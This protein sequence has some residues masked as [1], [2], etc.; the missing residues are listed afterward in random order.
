MDAHWK[1]VAGRKK[2]LEDRLKAITPVTEPASGDIYLNLVVNEQL[3]QEAAKDETVVVVGQAGKVGP[4]L[5]VKQVRMSVRGIASW[6]DRITQLVDRSKL[7]VLL[8]R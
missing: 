5:K 6:R 4:A 1:S 2:E 8:G 7:E 3:P